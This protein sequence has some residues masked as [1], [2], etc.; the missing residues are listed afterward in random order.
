MVNLKAQ[1]LDHC[2]GKSTNVFSKALHLFAFTMSP[3]S[4][5]NPQ[6]INQSI[7]NS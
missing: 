4:D 1:S 7:Y 6:L 3:K 2:E 5:D